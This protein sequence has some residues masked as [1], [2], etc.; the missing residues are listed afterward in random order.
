MAEARTLTS[1]AA[2]AVCERLPLPAYGFHFN[3]SMALRIPKPIVP[4]VVRRV[5]ESER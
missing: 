1:I 5:K 2:Q 4:W 3:P